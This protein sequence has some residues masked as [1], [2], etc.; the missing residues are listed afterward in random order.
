[1]HVPFRTSPSPMGISTP[2]AFSSG[3]PCMGTSDLLTSGSPIS[4]VMRP[5]PPAIL[6]VLVP[7]SVSISARSPSRTPRSSANR[8]K[9]RMPLP[10]ISASEPSALKM[11]ILTSPPSEGSMTTT[12][13]APT[14][15]R[16]WH[17]RHTASALSSGS[18]RI[19]SISMKSFPVASYLVN[20]IALNSPVSRRYIQVPAPWYAQAPARSLPRCRPAGIP[21][22]TTLCGGPS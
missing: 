8:N 10:H 11:R 18:R 7:A 3:G 9:A 21:R 4:T 2:I 16:R 19:P 15:L 20:C 12:P 1:M 14:P 17:R 22:R 6:T 5:P 13:S